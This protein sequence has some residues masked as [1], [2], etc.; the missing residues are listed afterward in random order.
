MENLKQIPSAYYDAAITM[1]GDC[2]KYLDEIFNTVSPKTFEAA[3]SNLKTGLTKTLDALILFQKFLQSSSPISDHLFP[4]AS[5][6][7][8]LEDHFLCHRSLEEI[9][10]I[11]RR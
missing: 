10:S 6:E 4:A 2:R 1:A 11:G 8:T 9:F 7:A 5:I 3:A